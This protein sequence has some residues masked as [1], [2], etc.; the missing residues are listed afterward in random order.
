MK[1]YI[2][3][4]KDFSNMSEHR[5]DIIEFNVK[6]KK[7]FHTSAP[8]TRED[9]Q[10]SGKLIPRQISWGLNGGSDFNKHIDNAIFCSLGTPY[11]SGYDDDIYEIDSNLCPNIFYI[12]FAVYDK[13]NVTSVY[14]LTEID[15]KYCKLIYK[16]TGEEYT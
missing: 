14:T 13:D 16:G 3:N 8:L 9:I 6:G 11:D 4:L 7:L 15:L 2:I 10:K 12:D 1:K 5:K